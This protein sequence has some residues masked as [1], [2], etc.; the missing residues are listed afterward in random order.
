MRSKLAIA[1]GVMILLSSCQK[2]EARR[3]I[4]YSKSYTL[5]DTSEQMKKLNT[6]E[7][8]KV[9]AYIQRDSL[10]DYIDSS[11]GYWFAYVNKVEEGISPKAEDIVQ[12]SYEIHDLNNQVIYSKE[13]LGIKIYKVDK[14]DFIPALQ[15]GI[16]FMKVGE[17]LKFV[18]PSYNAFGV[19]GDENRIGMNQSIISIVTLLNINNE[20]EN[21]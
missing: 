15:K 17:T 16:K 5:A 18:I 8:S 7:E 3:P 9:K 13:E 21:N 4:S 6:I 1:L 19:V 2:K 11:N 20:N 10:I 12:L 14:E